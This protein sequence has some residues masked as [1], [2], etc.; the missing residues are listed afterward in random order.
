MNVAAPNNAL[1]LIAPIAAPAV[2]TF[3]LVVC[4]ATLFAKMSLVELGVASA[5]EALVVCVALDNVEGPVWVVSL[6]GE[7]ESAVG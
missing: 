3:C 2:V 1:P 7:E 6:L 4:W 5:L